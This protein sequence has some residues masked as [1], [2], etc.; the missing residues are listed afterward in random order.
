MRDETWE[1]E[2]DTEIDTNADT[3][4]TEKF[5]STHLYSFCN[6]RGNFWNQSNIILGLQDKLNGPTYRALR[7]TRFETSDSQ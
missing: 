3:H 4:S 1:K 2:R 7:R 5:L 6:T